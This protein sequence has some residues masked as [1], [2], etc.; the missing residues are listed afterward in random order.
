MKVIILDLFFNIHLKFIESSGY[1]YFVDYILPILSFLGPIFTALITIIRI[2]KNNKDQI[3]VLR[4][5]MENNEKRYRE[6]NEIKNK[7]MLSIEKSIELKNQTEYLFEPNNNKSKPI[8]IIGITFKNYAKG[9]ANNIEICNL[10]NSNLFKRYRDFFIESGK[11]KLIPIELNGINKSKK[12]KK[13]LIV[14]YTPILKTSIEKLI[15]VYDEKLNTFKGYNEDNDKFKMYY[16]KNTKNYN[17]ILISY[18][19]KL[20]MESDKNV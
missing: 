11:E 16:R 7:P 20:G 19:Q 18:K 17:E 5:E 4:E 1:E 13:I 6:N 14:L 2:N 15:L 9:L 12:G 8:K 3:S 10:S